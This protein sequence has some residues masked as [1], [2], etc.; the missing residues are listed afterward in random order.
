MDQEWWI[1]IVYALIFLGLIIY[2]IILY[3]CY[4]Q[5]IFIFT[6][7]KQKV[8]PEPYFY[9]LAPVLQLTAAQIAARNANIAEAS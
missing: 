9:P 5:Q 6:P 7:Y 3:E 2:V 1:L 8:P 4:K